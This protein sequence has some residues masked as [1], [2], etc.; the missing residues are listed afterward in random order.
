MGAIPPPNWRGTSPNYLGEARG[1]PVTRMFVEIRRIDRLVAQVDPAADEMPCSDRRVRTTLLSRRR[2]MLPERGRLPG[3]LWM[4]AACRPVAVLA[5]TVAGHLTRLS[6]SLIP[7]RKGELEL[8]FHEE[9]LVGILESVPKL[10]ADRDWVVLMPS[11][12]RRAR[13]MILG[14]DERRRPS[15][16]VKV[17]R[18]EPNRLAL[19]LLA[20]LEATG[21]RFVFPKVTD[22]VQIG[23][24]WI[25]VEQPLPQLP[26][27][28]AR[29]EPARLKELTAEIQELVPTEAGLPCGHGDFG[30]WNVRR[31]SN[32]L[33][34]ILDWE[35]ATRSPM[36]ADAVWYALTMRLA[37]TNLRGEQ[38]GEGANDELRLVYSDHEIRRA[39]GFILAQRDELEPQEILQEVERS[40][41]LLEFERRL[42]A[43]LTTLT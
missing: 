3:G 10:R 37:T 15:V 21:A 12:S 35:Y 7:A 16:F 17:T 13:A 32:G 6:V 29:L 38:I 28:P 40:P 1:K 4:H 22:V 39:A 2:L 26:H 27:S 8:P 23:G 5:N 24:W 30:P 18:D 41:A 43:A 33:L 9:I 25:T 42:D 20:E 31:F 36:A 14:L 11:D 34:G 19:R